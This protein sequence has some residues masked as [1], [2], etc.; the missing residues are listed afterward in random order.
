MAI[1][2]VTLLYDTVNYLFVSYFRQM[3]NDQYRN[4]MQPCLQVTGAIETDAIAWLLYF[5]IGWIGWCYPF[6]YV[7]WPS[8]GKAIDKGQ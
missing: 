3:M 2:T 5:W 6:L 8:A 4:S 7:V 1:V